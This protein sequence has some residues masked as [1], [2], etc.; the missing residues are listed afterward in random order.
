M[1]G[2]ADGGKHV[3]GAIRKKHFRVVTKSA[4]QLA[5]HC[6]IAA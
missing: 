3:S 5:V 4:R 6:K 1:E 2:L